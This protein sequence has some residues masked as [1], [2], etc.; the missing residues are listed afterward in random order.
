MIL[1]LSSKLGTRIKV[2][3]KAVLPQDTNAL[4]D[5]S[6]HLFTA[7][8][9]QYVI[10]TNTA[11]LYSAIAYARG[12]KNDSQFIGR[13]LDVI[14][15][16]LADDGFGETYLQLIAPATG[17]VRFSKA[18]NRS[19]IG[20]MNDIINH[21]KFFLQER[22]ESPPDVARRMNEMPLSMLKY[23]HPREVFSLIVEQ[24]SADNGTSAK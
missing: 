24:Q 22:D 13:A 5:W 9:T 20:S 18:L 2:A 8:R 21:S 11:S 1:R 17:T 19:V 15:E 4:A 16:S 10:L 14:R 7:A 3:P 6:G 12:I 23:N